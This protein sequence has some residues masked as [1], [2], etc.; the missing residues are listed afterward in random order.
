M[1]VDDV[2][3]IK[4]QNVPNEEKINDMYREYEFNKANHSTMTK[5]KLELN[6][7]IFTEVIF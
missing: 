5:Q 4:E 7:Q 1:D 3:K 6:K 2:S